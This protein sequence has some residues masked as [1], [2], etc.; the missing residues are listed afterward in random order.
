MLEQRGEGASKVY[1]LNHDYLAWTLVMLRQFVQPPHRA[2]LV[3][4][5]PARYP[6]ELRRFMNRDHR[7]MR[8][9]GREQD[10]LLALRHITAGMQPGQ[11]YSERAMNAL[12]AAAIAFDDYATI[13]RALVSHGLIGREKDGSRYWLHEPQEGV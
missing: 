12:I 6:L 5:T 10:R 9:P 1:R 7:L 2:A 11:D 13:R 3:N 8:L 4:L